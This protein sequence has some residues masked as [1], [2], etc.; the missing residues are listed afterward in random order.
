LNRSQSLKLKIKTVSIV[1]GYTQTLCMPLNIINE[2]P[3]LAGPL[4]ITVSV[5]DT[6]TSPLNE[7]EF[8]MNIIDPEGNPNVNITNVDLTI[9]SL[10]ANVT[11]IQNITWVRSIGTKLYFSPG[12]LVPS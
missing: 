9:Y 10:I 4:S 7:T 8:A 3:T 6:T 1:D 2:A 12:Y 11:V 5:R